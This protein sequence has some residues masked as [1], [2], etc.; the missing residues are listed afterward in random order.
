MKSQEG[1]SF[2]PP[3]PICDRFAAGNAVAVG[4]GQRK[5]SQPPGL[6]R[7]LGRDERPTLRD[8]PIELIDGIDIPIGKVGVVPQLA[9][10]LL[11]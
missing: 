8:L 1:A 6:I 2:L 11:G 7:G 9:R 5:F 3:S 10:G 4:R